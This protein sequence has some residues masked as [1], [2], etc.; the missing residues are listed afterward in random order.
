MKVDE[1]GMITID[2]VLLGMGEDGH[3]ASLFPNHALLNQNDGAWVQYL[4]D[5]PKAPPCR[6]TLSL[7]AINNARQKLI[8]CAGAPKL[9]LMEE[10]RGGEARLDMPISLVINAVWGSD[11]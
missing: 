6:V 8:L 1:S 5:S 7:Q 2:L 11:I 9:A 4:C 3:T 10:I